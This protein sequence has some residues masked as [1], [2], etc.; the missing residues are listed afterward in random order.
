MYSI[1]LKRFRKLNKMTQVQAA[2]YFGC[3]QSFISLIETGRSKVP[4]A[5]IS[6]ILSDSDVDSSMLKKTEDIENEELPFITTKSG[7]KYYK[8]SDN[9]FRMRVPF[10]QIHAYAK[11]VDERQDA[12]YWTPEEE[13]EFLVDKIHHGNY[14]AFEI[15]GDSMDDDSKR[16]LSNGDIVLAR[17]LNQSL[18]ENKLHTSS[19]PNWIIVL[20]NTI[21]CKR[22]ADHNV[23][24]GEILCKSLNPS[25][26]YGDFTLNLNNVRQLF[27]IVQR[28]SLDF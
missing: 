28:V 7:I 16:S 1:D 24:T 17:Q 8:L 3:E 10:V 14:M 21:L 13:Y 6:K 18:W 25:P 5:F 23:E 2:L 11:Y 4:E 12:S 22:I 27:N 9:R 19:Y 20:D 26:E 15:K